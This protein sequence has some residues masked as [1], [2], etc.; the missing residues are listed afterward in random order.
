MQLCRVKKTYSMVRC[1][2]GFVPKEGKTGL[3]HMLTSEGKV[4]AELTV[5]CLGE[6][7]YLVVTGAG[8]EGHDLRRLRWVAR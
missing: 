5:T 4:Y 3:V 8:S 1:I 6:Q 2:A 7:Q